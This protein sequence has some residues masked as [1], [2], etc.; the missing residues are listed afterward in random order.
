MTEL[1]HRAA[2]PRPRDPRGGRGGGAHRDSVGLLTAA[3]A[4]AAA[5]A[6]VLGLLAVGLVV[7][8]TWA[9]ATHS[10]TPA[11]SA[12]RAAAQAW[13]LAHHTGLRLADGHLGL[14]PLGVTAGLGVLLAALSARAARA[15]E[16]TDRRAAVHLVL[17][18]AAAYAA[19]TVA[20]ASLASS[21]GVRPT[22][23]QGFVGALVL[24]LVS[25][26]VGVVRATGLG[27]A[28]TRWLPPAARV[29]AR[30]AA[31]AILVL[32]AAGA[33]LVGV[34]LALHAA[35]A[36]DLLVALAP[37][38]VG[39]GSLVAISLALV[40]N[41]VVWGAAF[42]VGPG[43][44]VGAGTGVSAFGVHLGAVPALPLLA[45]LPADGAAAPVGLLALLV[46]WVAG[47]L[48]GTLVVRGCA[49]LPRSARPSDRMQVAVAAAAG[50]AGGVV[51]GLL[52]AM[53][54]GP[55]G[56]G[57]MATV[58][59]SPWEVGLAAALELAAAA[60]LAAWALPPRLRGTSTPS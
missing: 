19:L 30:A 37:G 12:V 41:A 23:S 9:G 15:C 7:L 59:P 24:A 18:T 21:S 16:V 39:T 32:V 42:C 14:V 6:A 33:L 54:G 36:G 52:A 47:A 53:A 31:A 25:A 58:G 13:L 22:A 50:A 45:A 43:F 51:I 34:S 60:A 29:A 10:T 17:V 4:V 48:T 1:L 3:G 28:L 56:G 44:A 11:G 26:S 40:P 55:V 2:T 35:R 8:A 46:P 20:V 38:A 49:R 27:P 57:R 5:S